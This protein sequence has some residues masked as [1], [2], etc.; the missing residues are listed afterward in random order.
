MVEA[1]AVVTGQE[2][3]VRPDELLSGQAEQRSSEAGAVPQRRADRS[4][5]EE[6]ALDG[7]VLQDRALLRLEAVDAG[8]EQRVDRR[9]DRFRAGVGIVR[10]HRGLLDE[11]WVP[12]PCSTIRSRTPFA[13]SRSRRPSTNSSDSAGPSGS[14]RRASRAG[15]APPRSLHVEEVWP[16]EADHEDQR[17]ARPRQVLEQV[18]QHRLGPVDVVDD[19]DEQAARRE[20]LEE[21]AGRPAVSRASRARRGLGRA[22]DQRAA[23]S[24]VRGRQDPRE[25]GLRLLARDLA[26]DVGERKVR[27]PLPYATHRPT[28]RARR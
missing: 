10:E 1:E 5:V 26:H 28:T 17:A 19:D 6:P 22:G 12:R 15:A 4:T 27:D 9:R 8:G 24:P 2:R 11:E 16:R 20:R 14:G 3:A 23:A 21:G 7:C 13:T 25:T 18:E